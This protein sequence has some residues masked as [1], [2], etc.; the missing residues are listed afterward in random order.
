MDKKYAFFCQG[1]FII[2]RFGVL[3][4]LLFISCTL[5]MRT[6][7]I[8]SKERTKDATRNDCRFVAYSGMFSASTAFIAPCDCFEI[9]DSL[10]KWFPK[11]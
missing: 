1:N 3:I 4:A 8:Y 10:N 9:G 5:D 7:T 2:F 6:A 11:E